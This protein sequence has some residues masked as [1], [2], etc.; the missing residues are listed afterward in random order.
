MSESA[1]LQNFLVVG[2]LLFALGGIG[3]VVRRNLIVMFISVEIMLQG[4]SLSF[5]AWGRYHNDWGGQVMVLMIIAVAACEAAVALALILILAKKSGV[6]DSTR[7][8]DLR[9]QGQPAYVDR[10]VPEPSTDERLWP[11]LTPAGV[12]PEAD[13]EQELYRSRV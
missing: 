3:V 10:S 7:W 1:L 6:L 13:D 2:A 5:V 9:E 11:S 4:V 12:E 8:Q